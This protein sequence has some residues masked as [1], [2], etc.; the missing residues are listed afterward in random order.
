M[1]EPRSNRAKNRTCGPDD[2]RADAV[3][4]NNRIVDFMDQVLEFCWVLLAG[5]AGF[6]QV[7][8][9]SLCVYGEPE[10]TL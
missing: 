9:G 2:F 3:A 4:G 10:R 6:V 7:L 8:R 5:S 1:G